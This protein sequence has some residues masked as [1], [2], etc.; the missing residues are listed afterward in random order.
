MRCFGWLRG[1]TSGWWC[2]VV[3]AGSP[4]AWAAASVRGRG[5]RGGGGGGGGRGGG[6]GEVWRTGPPRAFGAR[7]STGPGQ[8][9]EDRGP[10]GMPAVVCVPLVHGGDVGGGLGV[11]SDKPGL[12][13]GQ[14]QI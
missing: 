5:W 8:P 13:V 10:D 2:G 9:R 11:A 3:P 1:R 12:A 4:P 14:A 6:E 7:P